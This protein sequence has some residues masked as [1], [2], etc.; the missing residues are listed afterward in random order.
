MTLLN[1]KLGRYGFVVSKSA[2]K[3]EIKNAVEAHYGVSV[4]KVNTGIQTGK[5]RSRYTKSGVIS[6]NTS[7][8]K[9]AI[10]TLVSGDSIDFYSNV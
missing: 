7:S 8:Y 10:V 1:E 5:A 6:G 9:K 4:V 2:N 3:L